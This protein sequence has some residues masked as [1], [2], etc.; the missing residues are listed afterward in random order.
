MMLLV[1]LLPIIVPLT[2][3][4]VFKL[5]ART[6]MSIAAVLTALCAS[7]IWGM[8]SEA[9]SAS[10]LQ[11]IHRA[12]T[13]V[14]ILIGAVTLLYTIQDSGAVKSIRQGFM[15]L[16]SDMRVQVVII[17]FAFLAM[18]EGVSGFGTPAVIV[19]PLL[20]TLGFRPIVAASV[21]LI[22]DTVACTFG[23]GALPLILGLENVTIYSPELIAQVAELVTTYDLLIGTAM[24]L[25]LVF[26]LVVW[27]GRG[28]LN[29]RLKAVGQIAPWALMVGLVYSLSAF[30]IIRTVGVEFAAV[31]AGLLALIVAALTARVGFL[32]PKGKPW[33][34]QAKADKE[35]GEHLLE[36][37]VEDDYKPERHMPLWRAWSPYI[38]VIVLLVLS[39]VIPP[40]NQFLNAYLDLSWLAI[41]GFDSINSSWQLLY[42]PGTILL[43]SALI[44]GLIQ[45]RGFEVVGA[46]FLGACKTALGSAL[47][48]VPTLIMVQ[49]FVNSHLNISDL[50]SMPIY[51]GEALGAVTGQAWVVFAPLLGALGAFIA[52]STTI[53]TLTLGAVQESIALSADLPVVL[54]LA[55]QMLGGAAGNVIAVHNVVAVAAV[56]GLVNK[57]G[58]V[59][60]RVVPAVAVYVMVAGIL[61]LITLM[62]GIL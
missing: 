10:A 59:I 17:G 8:F 35:L 36:N 62:L 9:I 39:R 20:I 25:G 57:E 41:L 6:T 5:S 22:S 19:A 33:R 50:A 43:V 13:V 55:M 29:E 30:V 23:A 27:F 42:S 24:P 18:I 45:T 12:L 52:G 15:K 7:F 3:L 47:A 46:S 37:P 38:I 14:W 44:G 26:I 54:I 32:I 28:N 48:L 4:A 11:G 58:Y 56:V 51:I 40:V 16:S 53:S 21:A 61:G 31:L 2:L 60:R 1:A 34:N 49:I